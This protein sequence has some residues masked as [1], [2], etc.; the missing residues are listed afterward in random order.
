M[1]KLDDSHPDVYKR[2]GN[3]YIC[4]R[5]WADLPTD[6]LME[7]VFMSSLKTNG[8]PMRGIEMSENQ[9]LIWLM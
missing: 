2:F 5:F 4:D 3:G 7:Q 6:L 8:G 9:R 1:L